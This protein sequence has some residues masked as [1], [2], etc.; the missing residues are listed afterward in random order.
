MKLRCCIFSVLIYRLLGYRD[1]EYHDEFKVV[2]CDDPDCV[3]TSGNAMG[4]SLCADHCGV[5]GAA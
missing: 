3:R 5:I 2:P 4:H 1:D